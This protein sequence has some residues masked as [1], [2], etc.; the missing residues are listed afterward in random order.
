[1]KCMFMS[2]KNLITAK[3]SSDNLCKYYVFN[4]Q[5]MLFYFRFNHPWFRVPVLVEKDAGLD[6]L[7]VR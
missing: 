3:T 7:S 4:L 6:F 1:M 2:S 5:Q